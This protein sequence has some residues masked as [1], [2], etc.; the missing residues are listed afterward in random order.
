MNYEEDFQTFSDFLKKYELNEVCLPVCV[1]PPEDTD[2]YWLIQ[3]SLP[4]KNR[5]IDCCV[6]QAT[7][8]EVSKYKVKALKLYKD[9][10]G[11]TYETEK[12][13]GSDDRSGNTSKDS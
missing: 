13:H 9:A 1:V 7:T 3:V 6:W 12:K 2:D 10:L 4:M 11:I 8:H 5:T